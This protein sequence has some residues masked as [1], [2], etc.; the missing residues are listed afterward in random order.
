MVYYG[1][2]HIKKFQDFFVDCKKCKK[3]FRVENEDTKIKACSFCHSLKIT[4]PRNFQLMFAVNKNK[5]EDKEFFYLRPETAQGIF[6][7]YLKI[8][9]A[10]NLKL[11][12]GIAQIGKSFRNEINLKNFLFRLREFEQMELEYFFEYNLDNLKNNFCKF[13]NLVF[14]FLLELGL[15]KTNIIIKDVAVNKLAHY[16]QKTLDFEFKFSFGTFELCGLSY[17]KNY[18]LINHQ[19]F[20]KQK[21][22]YVNNDN[23]KIIPHVIEPSFG[24]ERLVL[25][26]IDQNLSFENQRYCLNLPFFLAPF[27]VAILPLVKKLSTPALTIFDDLKKKYR[28]TFED[29]KTIG[30]RYYYQDAIGTFFAICYDYDSLKDNQ[31]TIRTRNNIHQERILISKIRNYIDNY[32]FK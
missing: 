25:A 26:V 2:K 7:N 20:S 16:A 30:K 5:L 18:D 23:Q 19:N 12:F 11:P 21:L 4:K 32:V 10:N 3:R 14:N 9:Q 29:K 22:F 27:Q 15:K 1:S 28:V 6:V 8:A 24:I 31:V 17:R 13:K